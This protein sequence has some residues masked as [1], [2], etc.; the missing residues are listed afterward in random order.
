MS[1]QHPYVRLF[2]LVTINFLALAIGIPLVSAQP[3]VH[4]PQPFAP[5]R[6]LVAFHPGTPAAEIRAAHSQAGGH[7]VKTIKAL[8]VQVVGVPA[9]TVAD[10]I[11]HYQ[12]NPN[13]KFA[14]PNYRRPLFLPVTLEGGEPSLGISNNFTEQWGLDNTGQAFGATVDPIFGTLIVPAYQGIVDADIDAPE[15]W[16]ISHGSAAIKIAI[17]DSGVSCS[18]VDLAD[19]CIEQVNF[20]GEH[21]SRIDDV[22]GHGTHVA[23]IAAAKTDNGKGVAGVAWDA[24]VG[25][26]K[27]CYEDYSLAILG[28]IQGFCEDADVAEAITYAV[29]AGYQVINMSLAGAEFSNTLQSAVDDA[30]NNG[31]VLVAGAGNDYSSEK[32]YPAAYNHVIAVGATDYIDNQASF[33]SFSSDQDDWVDVAAP[34]H[35]ILSTVPGELCGIAPDDPD[36]CYDW[37]SGTSMATPHVAGIAALLWAYLPNPSNVQI[38]QIIE[39]SADVVGAL[40]QNL[41]AW[42][43]YGRVNLYKALT[44]QSSG[45][46]PGDSDPPIISDV[47]ST[48]L[49][50]PRFEIS[51]ITDEPATSMVTLDGVLYNDDALV[52]NHSRTF[53]GQKGVTYEYYVSST[54]AAGNQA[55]E[56]PYQHRN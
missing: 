31:L 20:V 7:V 45:P 32:R 44:Y 55:T 51:W 17:L 40:G 14:E 43:K 10:A 8:G 25:S 22:I 53:S 23:G 27:V 49:K 41:L 4:P 3:G 46:G 38:R 37:K 42:T 29:V 1:L 33:S 36:G 39:Q 47:T 21:G 34:G 13:V 56:G 19:K 28:I 30:W 2:A 5:D 50:G 12:R 9:G 35:V 11:Q 54:D 52:T 24:S 26:L 48:K 16:A 18:H 6:V 15:G